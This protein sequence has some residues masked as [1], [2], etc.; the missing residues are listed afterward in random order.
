LTKLGEYQEWGV[1][2]VWLVDPWLRKLNVYSGRLEE[3]ER[4]EV[5]EL[6]IS[7]RAEDLFD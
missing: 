2:H 5:A 6:S 1:P 4:L 7:I 3:I